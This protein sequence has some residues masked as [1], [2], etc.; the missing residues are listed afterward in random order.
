M[1]KELII[2]ANAL[3][4]KGLRA[5]ADALDRIIKRAGLFDKVRGMFSSEESKLRADLDAIT[6][7]LDS[8]PQWGDRSEEES[9]LGDKLYGELVA[10]KKRLHEI[11]PEPEP[12]LDPSDR[13]ILITAIENY[14]RKSST[15][16]SE[17]QK[18]RVK[19]ISLEWIFDDDSYFWK[20]KVSEPDYEHPDNP[21]KDQEADW[22]M[23]YGKADEIIYRGPTE[24]FEINGVGYHLAG[25]N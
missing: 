8:L 4:S 10:A 18:A 13:G 24:K 21:A 14:I 19:V 7:R 15:N 23:W 12:F 16:L 6:E 1:I 22:L 20:A 17:E 11:A 9:E 5:E 25:E 3:D 2:L